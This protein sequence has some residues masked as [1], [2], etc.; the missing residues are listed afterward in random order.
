[1]LEEL[2]LDDED[3]VGDMVSCYRYQYWFS[4][5][6]VGLVRCMK[7]GRGDSNGS[8][9]LLPDLEVGT[10]DSYR[11]GLGDWKRLFPKL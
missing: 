3:D 2:E 7:G 5:V 10:E 4:D 11:K 1:L 9:S 6:N 8:L